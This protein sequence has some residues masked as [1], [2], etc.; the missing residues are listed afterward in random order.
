MSLKDAG[1][2]DSHWGKGAFDRGKAF[3]NELQDET[4]SKAVKEGVGV[5]LYDKGSNTFTS[6][7]SINVFSATYSDYQKVAEASNSIENYTLKKSKIKG[8]VKKYAT[9]LNKNIN[10]IDDSITMDDGT[11]KQIALA[12]EEDRKAEILLVVPEELSSSDKRMLLFEIASEIETETGVK[13]NITFRDK[14]LS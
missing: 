3:V 13:V 5:D 7:H 9:D 10:K 1:E 4:P 11:V 8:T 2:T 12:S 6:V 14:A